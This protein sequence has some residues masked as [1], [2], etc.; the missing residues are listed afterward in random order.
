[1]RIV[2]IAN[3]KGGVGKTTT[4]VNLAAC[5]ALAGKEVLL[6]DADPQQ[7]ALSALGMSDP[8]ASRFIEE[9]AILEPALQHAIAVPQ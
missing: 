2:A 4:A 1:M 8:E 6:V 5:I 9:G 3:H 7:N